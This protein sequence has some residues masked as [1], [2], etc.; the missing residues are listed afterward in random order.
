MYRGPE[1]APGQDSKGQG[2][3]TAGTKPSVHPRIPVVTGRSQYIF[4]FIESH[5]TGAFRRF[6]LRSAA[7][8][9]V[10]RPVLQSRVVMQDRVLAAM[11]IQLHEY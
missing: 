10:G 6:L 2:Q 8:T 1:T 4:Q 3:R 9:N 5:F 7:R 11:R